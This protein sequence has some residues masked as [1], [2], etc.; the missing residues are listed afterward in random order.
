VIAA[1]AGLVAPAS[2]SSSVRVELFPPLALRD[3]PLSVRVSGLRP[4]ERVTIR[5]EEQS[6]Q[7]RLWR[8]SVSAVAGADGTVLLPRTSLDGLMT[9][10]NGYPASDTFP[11]PRSTIRVAVLDGTRLLAAT[12]AVR[13]VRPA[14]VRVEFARPKQTGIYGDYF[15]PARRSNAVPMIVMGG[16]E[17]G[18]WVG[19]RQD[20]SLLAAH[21]HPTLA[22]AYFGEPGLPAQLR[23]IPLEYFRR[24]LEWLRGRSEVHGRRVVVQGT[25]YGG[26]AVLLIGA[27]YPALVRGVVALVPDDWVDP[28]PG[29]G[30]YPAWTLRGKP[31]PTGQIAVQRIRGPIFAVGGGEDQLWPSWSHVENLKQDL[32][33]HGPRPT[34][35]VYPRAGHAVGTIVPYIPSPTHIHSR[36][37]L[38]ELGGTRTADERAREDAWPKLLAWLGRLASPDQSVGS[39]G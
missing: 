12:T 10:V 14:D 34:L 16:S 27:T 32:G 23:S 35:L 31:I 3:V 25:S 33:G 17:G 5:A 20:A 39:P 8:S 36:Y 6:T 26:E 9:P 15:V 24:A 13:V 38:L 29:I 22:L 30:T 2:G 4:Q 11:R 18:L 28:A 1:F 21:G 37:G 7:G 19:V